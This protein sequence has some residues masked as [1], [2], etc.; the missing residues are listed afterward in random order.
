M[1][2]NSFIEYS[3]WGEFENGQ[4]PLCPSGSYADVADQ[5][6]RAIETGEMWQLVRDCEYR[7]L[8]AV[9]V[10]E[11][12]KARDENGVIYRS[13]FGRTVFRLEKGDEV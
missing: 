1:C 12:R 7:G 4:C 2:P 10:S 3:A 11:Y 13:D 5:A 9:S 8:V 6:E